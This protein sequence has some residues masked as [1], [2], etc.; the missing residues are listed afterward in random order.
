MIPQ[1]MAAL[2]G[3]GAIPEIV[4]QLREIGGKLNEAQAQERLDDK[5]SRNR[6][7]IERVLR[8]KDGHGSPTDSTSPISGGDE[9][10][11]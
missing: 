4:E 8:D 2:K 6:S 3:L 5:R 1:I 11:S 10:S 7:A 9:G